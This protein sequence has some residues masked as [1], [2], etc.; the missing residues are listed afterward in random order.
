MFVALNGNA[1]SIAY[2]TLLSTLYDSD[3]PVLKPS[4]INDLSE[5]QV[6]D[7]REKEEFEVSH[8]KGAHWVGYDTFDLANV[9]D[10]DKEKPVLVYCTVGARSQNIGEQLKANGFKYVYNLYGGIIQWSNEGLPLY[11]EDKRTQKVHTYSKSWGIW[12]NKGEKVY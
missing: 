1:Q 3:F 2:R 4:E 9:A 6:V 8:L 11:H 10:L 12:L 7:S 5:F